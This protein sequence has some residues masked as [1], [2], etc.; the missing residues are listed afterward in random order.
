MIIATGDIYAQVTSREE[1][2]ELMRST[3][4]RIREQPGCLSY[5]FA[6]SLDDPAHFVILQEWRDQEALDE[7]F[8]S[9][10]FAD[11]QA[12]IAERLVRSSELRVHDV[13]ASYVPFVSAPLANAQDD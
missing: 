10:A 7:H 1:V 4:A 8:R 5:T 3:Q 13:R 6:E 9:R 12:Q 2:R 11:Y